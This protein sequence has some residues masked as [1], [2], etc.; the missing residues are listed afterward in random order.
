MIPVPSSA[1]ESDVPFLAPDF[2]VLFESAPG[3]FLV[4]LPEDPV[5]TIVA[6]SDDFV[7]LTNIRREDLL[8]QG[9][10]EVFPDNPDNDA[11]DGVRNLRASFRRVMA[12]GV[13]DQMP[14]Q[15]YDTGRLPAEGG[16]FEERYWSVLNKPVLGVDGHVEYLLQATEEVTGRVRAEQ[17]DAFLVRLDD[18]T[19]PLI[20][21]DEIGQRATR[22]LGEHLGADCCAYG[23][24][25]ADEETIEITWNYCRSG[26]P[27][28]VGRYQLAQFGAEAARLLRAGRPHMVEDV[29]GDPCA[30][31]RRAIYHQVGIR[32]GVSVLLGKAGKL[33]ALMTVHQTTPRSWRKDEVE[34]VQAVANRCW[35]S[36]ERAHITRA[37]R[38]SER[39]FRSLVSASSQ[40]LYRM[41]PDWTEMRQLGG[42]GFLQD[43][44]QP[45]V[46]WLEQYID[47]SDQPFIRA[48]IERAVADRSVFELEHRVRS[49]DGSLGW[50][51]SRAVPVCNERGEITEWFGEANDITERKQM[52]LA[53]RTSQE[54]LKQIFQQA[55]VAIAVYRG[56]DFVIEL[57]NP[58]FT[59]LLPGREDFVGHRLAD[60][61]PELG[62]SFWDTFHRVLDTGEAFVANEFC[63]PYDQDG[64]SVV[65]DHW[66]NVVYHPLRE[67]DHSVSGIVAV[68]SEVT[69]QVRARQELERVNRELEEFAYVASHDLQ[70]PLRMTNIYTQLILQHLAGNDPVLDEYAGFVRQGVMRMEGLIR[71]L[72]AYS[73]T[74]HREPLP[75]GTANLSVSFREAV[76]V[77]QSRIE[78]CKATV[79]VPPLPAVRGD[80]KQMTQ[81]FQ[82]LLSNA[83][84]YRRKEVPLEIRISVERRSNEWIIAVQDNGIGFDPQYAERIFGLFKRL[85]KGEYP[86]TGLGLAICQ[87]IVERYGGRLWAEGRPG[88]GATFSFALPS[89]EE[90]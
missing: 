26:V 48:A 1:Q 57:A 87:R 36:L 83:L 58:S 78:E 46:R 23:H 80:T 7:R 60:V 12:T 41:S 39:R 19:R 25:E 27:S 56:R 63:V 45:S 69:A 84:K 73:R 90:D 52:E 4:L 65:E 59:P 77:L 5:F 3:A 22:L 24:F 72:L 16:G 54:R 31:D 76:A 29:E 11:A 33:V 55:P 51:R 15:R 9:V 85:H 42:G 32:A 74:V 43:T 71:D 50:T 44:E 20:D 13:P 67:S 37:L 79:T 61:A 75:V 18:A 86:G 2:R 88:Q 35:E 6:A 17:R 47:P 49:V 8:G 21:P 64:D 14:M 30:A 10:F 68:S 81:V 89:V 62:S 53:L 82:N 66:F 38:E 28:M 70:E 34:L 40:V